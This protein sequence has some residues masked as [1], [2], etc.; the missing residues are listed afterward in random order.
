[1]PEMEVD[2]GRKGLAGARWLPAAHGPGR[3]ASLS[4]ENVQ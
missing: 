2:G 1:M 3:Q 4:P